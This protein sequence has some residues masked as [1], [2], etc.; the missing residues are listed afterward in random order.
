MW[1]PR[2]HQRLRHVS[3]KFMNKTF[4]YRQLGT[5][6]EFLS[7]NFFIQ[8]LKFMLIFT[9]SIFSHLYVYPPIA[10]AS[11]MISVV[12]TPS[13]TSCTTTSNASSVIS[14]HSAESDTSGGTNRFRE[15]H[16]SRNHIPSIN[17]AI[18]AGYSS[19]LHGNYAYTIPFIG[20]CYS[21]YPVAAYDVNGSNYSGNTTSSKKSDYVTESNVVV[22]SYGSENSGIIISKKIKPFI[23]FSHLLLE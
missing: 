6:N 11:S 17:P 15:R 4:T 23:I 10:T 20:S 18:M 9:Y 2:C 21:N 22:S 8:P 16:Y 12:S 7:P 13:N 19:N 3:V 1:W 14:S 5:K